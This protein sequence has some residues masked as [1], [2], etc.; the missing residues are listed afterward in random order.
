MKQYVFAACKAAFGFCL[1]LLL[2]GALGLKYPTSAGIIL[3]LSLQTT[4]KETLK[5]AAQRLLAF[6]S[7]VLLAFISFRALGYTLPGFIAY[8]G[9]F[10]LVCNVLSL[11]NS[12]AVCSV[13]IA[14]LWT[15]QSMSLSLLRNELLLMVIGAGLGVAL[16]LF[17]PRHIRSVRE[18]QR[19]IEEIMR[20]ILEQMAA[21]LYS[22]DANVE[23]ALTELDKALATA[24]EKARTA[25]GNTLTADLRYYTDYIA[26]RRNQSAVLRRIQLCLERLESVPEQAYPI[27]AFLRTVA[28]SFHEYNNA[29]ILLH[30][31]EE[32][33]IQYRDTPLPQTR[34]EFEARAMLFQALSDL[35]Y[36]LLLKNTFASHLTEEQ[37]KTFWDTPASE[38]QNVNF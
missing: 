2:A 14:H 12:I 20:G 38:A 35:E 3:L 37:K 9:L 21:E 4:K 13:L 17:M 26:M 28:A 23:D 6:L 10:V 15:E 25:A 32:I 31:A 33:R 34:D 27:A 30:E 1:A 24:E 11:Q 18:E 5:T 22:E 7:G 16:N 36:F 8:I 29:D 19:H